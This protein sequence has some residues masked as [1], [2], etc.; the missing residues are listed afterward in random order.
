[1]PD[2][3]RP[4]NARGKAAARRIGTAL[5]ERRA[6]F[7]LVLTSP[8]VRTLETLEGV[9]ETY[10][11]GFEIRQDE[12]IYLADPA[13]LLEIVRG[14]PADV[15]GLLVVGHNPGLERLALLL[16]RDGTLRA[17]LHDK[18]PT[19][20]I[21]EIAFAC[22]LWSQIGEAS[23]TIGLFVVPRDLDGGNNDEG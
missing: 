16:S 9:R 1:M 7:D 5:R 23:G 11:P 20:G 22:D 21:V 18:F 4:L 13:T 17:R 8:A 14:T 15:A 12:R 10:G 3:E 2:F 19:G 6:S